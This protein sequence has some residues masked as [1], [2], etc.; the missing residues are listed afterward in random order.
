MRQ[1]LKIKIALVLG[2][3]GGIFVSVVT[4][5]TKTVTH[6]DTDLRAVHGL[7]VRVPNHGLQVRVPNDMKIFPVG[8]IPL[9]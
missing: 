1:I 6:T 4:S 7:Q 2:V 9:P 3:L 8:L 5:P